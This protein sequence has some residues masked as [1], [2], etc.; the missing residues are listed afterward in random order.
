MHLVCA[1]PGL[2]APQHPNTAWGHEGYNAGVQPKAM[3]HEP[4]H[5]AM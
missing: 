1:Q 4:R 2:D 3:L 5:Q